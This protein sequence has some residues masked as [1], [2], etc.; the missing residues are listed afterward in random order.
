MNWSKPMKGEIAAAIRL[1]SGIDMGGDRR[2]ADDCLGNGRLPS[3]WSACTVL[4]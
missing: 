4:V 3:R 2:G 1:L